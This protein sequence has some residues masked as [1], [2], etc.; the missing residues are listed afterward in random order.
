[1]KRGFTLIELLV[2]VLIIGILA[3]VALPQ[4][5]K[6]IA[7]SRLSGMLPLLTKF[8]TDSDLY[9]QENGTYENLNIKNLYNFSAPLVDE[10]IQG[11]QSLDTSPCPH[12]YSSVARC[13]DFFVNWNDWNNPANASIDAYYCPKSTKITNDNFGSWEKCVYDNPEKEYM[14]RLY[15]GTSTHNGTH[16]CVGYT[17]LGQKVCNSL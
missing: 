13:G 15:L 7:K 12:I 10:F 8:K 5:N 2:V 1:M 14:Y 3:A 9:Y 11:K 4:Y 6:A 16:S 17:E